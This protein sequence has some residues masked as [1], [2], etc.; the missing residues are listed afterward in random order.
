MKE[1]HYV[2]AF[3]VLFGLETHDLRLGRLIKLELF[4]R[5]LLQGILGLA[6]LQLLEN[7]LRS[8]VLVYELA[9]VLA[10]LIPCARAQVVLDVVEVHDCSF[11]EVYRIL[12]SD[13]VLHRKEFIYAR[14]F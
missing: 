10:F 13:D 6:F 7:S 2:R 14:L 4:N 1:K 11:L 9:V 12:Q 8:L 5:V 3:F